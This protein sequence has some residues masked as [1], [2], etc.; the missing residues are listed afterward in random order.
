MASLS[1]NSTYLVKAFHCEQVVDPGV[2]AHLV[3]HGDSGLHRLFVK[4]THGVGAVRSRYQVRLL[5]DTLFCDS[6][7]KRPGQ[8]AKMGTDYCMTVSRGAARRGAYTSPHYYIV[9]ANEFRHLVGTLLDVEEHRFCAWVR[10]GQP[11]GLLLERGSH[12]HPDAIVPRQVVHH[13]PGHV[14]R[15][16]NENFPFHAL[17]WEGIKF[18]AQIY[19]Y[20]RVSSFHF[21]YRGQV[22]MMS[23]VLCTPSLFSPSPLCGSIFKTKQALNL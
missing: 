12:R 14:S 20:I 3:D 15:S 13:R 4:R 1:C 11:L 22:F 2:G 16:Q 19:K 23:K 10:I 9:T 5:R 17:Q 8:E 7:V 6:G 21:L 18:W